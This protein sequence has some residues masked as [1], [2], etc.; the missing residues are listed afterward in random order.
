MKDKGTNAAC[1]ATI[2]ALVAILFWL[3]CDS[4]VDHM[5]MSAQRPHANITTIGREVP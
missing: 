5:H 1:A 4:I 3:A 2:I